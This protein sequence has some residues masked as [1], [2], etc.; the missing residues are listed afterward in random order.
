MEN[1]STE[2]EIQFLQSLALNIVT[3]LLHMSSDCLHCLLQ[4]RNEIL[5]SIYTIKWFLQCFLDR[6]PFTLTLRLWDVYILEGERLLI[7]MA[8]NLLK[9]H[10]SKSRIL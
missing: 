2:K 8:Y 7:G 9:M 5:S 6:V 3:L 10:K 4:E 1:A